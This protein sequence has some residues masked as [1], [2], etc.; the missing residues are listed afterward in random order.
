M[1]QVYSWNPRKPL[2]PGRFSKYSRFRGRVNNF[3]DLLGGKIVEA[4]LQRGRLGESAPAFPSQQLLSVGSVLHEAND[5]DV[6]WGSGRNGKKTPEQHRF[7]RLDVRAVRGPLTRRFLEERGL[8]VP[9][10]FGDPALLLPK[11]YPETVRWAT[12]KQRKYAVVPNFNEWD[13]YSSA[14]NVVNPLGPLASVIEFIAG[15]EYVVG[16]SLHGV[17]VAEALGIPAVAIASR[18][19]PD[20]KYRDYHSGTGRSEDSLI[21][22][23]DLESG[24]RTA[25]KLEPPVMDWSADRLLGAFPQELWQSASHETAPP[26]L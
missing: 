23:D 11:L 5:G 24:L 15:S 25:A 19:E 1:P 12:N 21:L 26:R 14:P 18:V 13:F 9:K 8:D 3:G 16:S 10:T 4:V 17:I 6:I 22:A 2:L 20:F 7:E